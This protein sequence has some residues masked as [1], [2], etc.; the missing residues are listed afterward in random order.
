MVG[1]HFSA[2]ARHHAHGGFVLRGSGHIDA[3]VAD[4][5]TAYHLQVRQRFEY[6]GRKVAVGSNHAIG[7][8]SIADDGFGLTLVE[9]GNVNTRLLRHAHFKVVVFEVGVNNNDFRH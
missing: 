9:Q 3:V 4:A 6:F 5:R 1:H 7:I 2:V 8:G